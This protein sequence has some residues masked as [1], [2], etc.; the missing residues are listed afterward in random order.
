MAPTSSHHNKHH[1]LDVY[2]KDFWYLLKGWHR[3]ST[4]CCVHHPSY[5]FTC[6]RTH[7]HTH[8]SDWTSD[9]SQINKCPSSCSGYFFREINFEHQRTGTWQEGC[10]APKPAL[11]CKVSKNGNSDKAVR[12]PTSQLSMSPSNVTAQPWPRGSPRSYAPPRK[13]ERT[14]GVELW[15]LQA[16]GSPSRS[17][18]PGSS[19]GPACKD[20]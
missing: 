14:L 6:T 9:E 3:L 15:P 2:H 1:H 11:E 12:S 10:A 20:R 13:S 4:S 18:Q 16:Q 7:T 19:P 8:F 5:W 17:S